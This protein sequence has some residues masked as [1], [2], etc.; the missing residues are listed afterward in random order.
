MKQLFHIEN[1][2]DN[3]LP[4]VL[5]IRIGEKHACF[6]ISDKTAAQLIAFSYCTSNGWDEAALDE[7][8]SVYPALSNTF[9]QV[10]VAYDFPEYAFVPQKEYRHEE[11]GNLSKSLFA[12][13][14]GTTLAEAIPA[15]QLQNVFTVPG[16]I[17][18]W[19][20]RKF[21]AVN[22][23]HQY[24]IGLRNIN[25]ADENGN[26]LVDIRKDDFTVMV[27]KSGKF[28]LAQTYEYA[29]PE[30]VLYYLL[31]ITNEFSLSR[32]ECTLGLSGLIDQQS[33]LYKELYLYFINLEFRSA[34][35][36]S[37][38]YPSHFFTSLNDL[39][40]CAS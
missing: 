22:C 28:L 18:D 29:T 30:D 1:P 36:N 15:W 34:T 14:A 33:S 5:A 13:A 12:G 39:A 3:N 4:Q 26:I 2:V 19:I 21:P 40:R 24:S 31:K 7:F 32:E 16:E 37:G 10:V 38:E 6:S 23:W 17:K 11:T 27:A 25:A 8:Y 35:W 9:F 20:N